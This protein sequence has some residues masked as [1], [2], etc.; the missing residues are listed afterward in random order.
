MFQYFE[1]YFNF[2]EYLNY[3]IF[4]KIIRWDLDLLERRG[5]IWILYFRSTFNKVDVDGSGEINMQ[6]KIQN[7]QNTFEVANIFPF[8]QT[9]F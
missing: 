5:A 3:K 9:T 8:P 7:I 1:E 6:V 4:F 2:E